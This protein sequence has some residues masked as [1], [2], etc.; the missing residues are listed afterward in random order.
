MMVYVMLAGANV[1]GT[2]W[3]GSFSPGMHKQRG[4]QRCQVPNIYQ[5]LA[6]ASGTQ[7][8]AIMDLDKPTVGKI[9]QYWPVYMRYNWESN[10]EC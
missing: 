8:L 10:S 1:F 2:L 6:E 9:V 3:G 5:M 4:P 7:S